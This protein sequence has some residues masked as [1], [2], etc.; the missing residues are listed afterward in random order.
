MD[1]EMIRA[2]LRKGQRINGRR[3]DGSKVDIPAEELTLLADPIDRRVRVAIDIENARICGPVCFQN[4]RLCR[5]VF[6]NC[7]FTDVVELSGSTLN[8]DVQFSGCT[9]PR[10][11]YLPSSR[12]VYD[13]NISDAKLTDPDF[14]ALRVGGFVR[15]ERATFRTSVADALCFDSLH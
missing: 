13:F 5:F 9:L 6:R 2:M 8:G 10:G 1:A 7:E 15:A 4:A 14:T 3:A 11:L 12:V